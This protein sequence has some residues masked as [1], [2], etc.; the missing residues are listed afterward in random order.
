MTGG[1]KR[2]VDYIGIGTLLVGV[3]VLVVAALALRSAQRSVQ[4]AEK[5][6]DYL[7]EEQERMEFLREEHKSL[8]VD[9]ERE[10]QECKNLREALKRERQERSEVQ[11]DADLAHQEA[12]GA[13]ARHLRGRMDDYI[14]DLEEDTSPGIRR[15]K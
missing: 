9:L 10:R 12:L 5:R 14:R 13:A 7:L 11:R 2:A 8:Q 1:V 15:V 4:L 6:Q 3:V